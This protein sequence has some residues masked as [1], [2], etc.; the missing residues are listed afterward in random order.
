MDF[1]EVFEIVLPDFIII[2]IGFFAARFKRFDFNAITE[3]ILYVTSPCLVV[4]SLTKNPIAPSELGKIFASAF[5]IVAAMGVI[6]WLILKAMG[7]AEAMR[8][9]LLPVMFMNS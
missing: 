1:R 9:I 3:L 7:K 2:G 4:A 8:G 5:I 6:A